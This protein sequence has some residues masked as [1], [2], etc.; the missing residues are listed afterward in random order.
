VENSAS[1]T[2]NFGDILALSYFI[3]A[4]MGYVFCTDISFVQHPLEIWLYNGY[5]EATHITSNSFD[6]QKCDRISIYSINPNFS[7]LVVSLQKVTGSRMFIRLTATR[8]TSSQ[9]RV[10]LEGELD[11]E[12]IETL[13]NEANTSFHTSFK[14]I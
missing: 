1:M 6:S 11:K 4:F 13:A 14:Y 5:R 3:D 8:D 9:I 10:H 2:I 7:Y 12:Q